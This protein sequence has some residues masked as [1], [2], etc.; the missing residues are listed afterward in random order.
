MREWIWASYCRPALALVLIFRVLSIISVRPTSEIGDEILH[1]KL[2]RDLSC[3]STRALKIGE[4]C[5]TKPRK[6]RLACR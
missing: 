2:H 6:N 4:Q 5:R 3:I 1:D